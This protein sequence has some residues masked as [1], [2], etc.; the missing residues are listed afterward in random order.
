[1]RSVR[2]ALI[3]VVVLRG[4]APKNA[5][6]GVFRTVEKKK[7]CAYYFKHGDLYTNKYSLALFI[8]YLSVN[9]PLFAVFN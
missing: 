6:A 1:M 7:K 4:L 8:L 5:L 2:L 9:L 3:F